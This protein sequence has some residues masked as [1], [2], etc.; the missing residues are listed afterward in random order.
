MNLQ[1]ADV[2]RASLPP[3]RFRGVDAE[4]QL[5]Q[6]VVVGAGTHAAGHVAKHLAGFRE[7]D[8]DAVIPEKGPKPT[9]V[10]KQVCSLPKAGRRGG[11]GRGGRRSR[12]GL[13]GR[14]ALFF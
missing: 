6:A 2:E 10:A 1:A 14:P 11:S 8:R 12:S 13:A 3:E 5:G 4:A 9:D 7:P